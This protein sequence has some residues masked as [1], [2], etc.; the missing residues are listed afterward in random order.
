[1][2]SPFAFAPE[3]EQ[4]FDAHAA[5]ADF[6]EAFVEI[7]QNAESPTRPKMLPIEKFVIAVLS[8]HIY[9]L[10][11]IVRRKADWPIQTE[12]DTPSVFDDY[13]PTC[14]NAPAIIDDYLTRSPNDIEIL[15]ALQGASLHAFLVDHLH[16][17]D[18][19]V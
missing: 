8:D 1:M 17:I 3:P 12:V 10:L 4:P 13:M 2:L 19:D 16:L 14:P 5:L 18:H 9:R 6:I 7:A 11:A 15:D